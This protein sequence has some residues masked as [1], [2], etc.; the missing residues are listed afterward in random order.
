MAIPSASPT[1]MSRRPRSSGFSAS[2]PMAAVPTLATAQPAPSEDKPVARAAAIIAQPQA[3]PCAAPAPSAA[4]DACGE[5]SASVASTAR[6]AAART[7]PIAISS[8]RFMRSLLEGKGRWAKRTEFPSARREKAGEELEQDQ[9][10]GLDRHNQRFDHDDDRVAENE[11]HRLGDD[12]SGGVRQGDHRRRKPR[13][14]EGE[15]ADAD[16]RERVD[17]D[18]EGL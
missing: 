11:D 6:K 3:S 9:T 17:Q 4:P 12:V 8:F 1:K 10:R 16:E 14:R 2:A 13:V 7:D 15:R 18:L 5:T